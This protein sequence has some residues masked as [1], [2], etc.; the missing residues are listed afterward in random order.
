MT[1]RQ[2]LKNTRIH[3]HCS[4][5]TEQ[6]FTVLFMNNITN[7]RGKMSYAELAEISCWLAVIGS[8]HKCQLKRLFAYRFLFQLLFRFSMCL[9]RYQC[10]VHRTVISLEYLAFVSAVFFFSL[11]VRVRVIVQNSSRLS[12]PCS[13]SGN[14]YGS[15]IRHGI[16]GGLNCDPASFLGFV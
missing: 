16:F 9:L 5:T 4:G 15:E 3:S 6:A 8:Q 7:K 1:K 13:S 2:N 14:F 12:K 10:T 11:L